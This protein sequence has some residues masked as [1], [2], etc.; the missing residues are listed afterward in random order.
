MHRLGTVEL[1]VCGCM[2]FAALRLPT[3]LLVCRCKWVGMYRGAAAAEY[4]RYHDEEWGR[5]L[6]DDHKL[7]ELLVLEGAQAGLSWSTIL[8]KREGYRAAFEG[9]DPAKVAA[10]DEARV[11]ALLAEGSGVVKHKGKLASAVKNARVFL[12]LQR[13]HGSFDS[14]V[15]RFVPDSMPI[16][17]SWSSMDQIPSKTPEAEALSKALK[18][19]GMTFVGPTICYAFMQAAGLVNDH[20]VDCHCYQPIVDS[21]QHGRQQQGQH[22]HGGGA[23]A[24]AADG[25]TTDG[26]TTKQKGRPRR[27]GSRA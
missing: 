4:V 9:F 24:A 11:E 18:Q 23:A 2:C 8:A 12:E 26:A 25:A 17:N 20:T 16:I 10:F 15:W 1:L 3:K 27:G 5:A 14:Y 21:Y 13:Q 22:R 7:F 19:A 6:H